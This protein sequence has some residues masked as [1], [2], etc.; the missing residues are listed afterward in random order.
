MIKVTVGEQKP[1]ET[2][3]P[4][5]MT[6]KIKGDLIILFTSPSVGVVVSEGIDRNIGEFRTDWIMDNFED[7]NGEVKLQNS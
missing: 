2:K 1:Q 3:F 7:F 6:R 5:L 4:R